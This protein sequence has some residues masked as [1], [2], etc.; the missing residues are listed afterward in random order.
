MY[1]IVKTV[2]IVCVALSAAGFFLRGMLMLRGS[3]LL[4][5]VWLRVL[6]HI[7]DTLL[8]VAAITLAVM[9][10]QYPFV[11]PWLTAKVLGL[12]VYIGL[13]SLALSRRYRH[14]PLAPRLGAWCLALLVLA[15]IVS[16]AL[17]RQ[18]AGAFSA[19]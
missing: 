1:E 15:W 7:N 5:A 9:S 12:L 11:A 14:Y 8:L 19:L 10:T 2:H 16:V 17:T 13:G 4:D 6:P 3:P 18:P